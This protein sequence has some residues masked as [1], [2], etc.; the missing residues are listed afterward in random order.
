M[1]PIIP[2]AVLAVTAGA[3]AITN[4]KQ[5]KARKEEA[6]QQ[7]RSARKYTTYRPGPRDITPKQEQTLKPLLKEIAGDKLLIGSFGVLTAYLLFIG[8]PP[9]TVAFIILKNL[10][11]TVAVTL[12]TRKIFGHYTP[13]ELI[14]A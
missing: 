2:I 8:Y 6:E 14:L 3:V 7:A 11:I 12:M 1:L 10:L 4:H 9:V 5:K 13:G